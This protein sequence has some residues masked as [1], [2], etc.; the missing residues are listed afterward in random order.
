VDFPSALRAARKAAKMNQKELADLAGV[1]Q[2]SIAQWE[3]GATR[4]KHKTLAKL[5]AALGLPAGELAQYLPDTSNAKKIASVMVPLV[6]VVDA[7]SGRDEPFDP[8]EYILVSSEWAGCI[9]YEVRGD[10]MSDVHICNG[11]RLIV[12]PAKNQEPEPG[13]IVV[14]WINIGEGGHVVKTLDKGGVLR[15]FGTGEFR[16]KLRDGDEIRG[17][18][19]DLK[20]SYRK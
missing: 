4:V 9:A 18:L 19:V 6:G 2:A 17:V 11:D 5:E 1:S 13:D 14:A 20:R 8:S 10:S 12:L 7:G 16:Y 3:T 15:S